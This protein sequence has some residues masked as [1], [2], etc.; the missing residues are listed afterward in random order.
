MKFNEDYI[1]QDIISKLTEAIKPA[2][3]IKKTQ[4]KWMLKRC[5]DV[6]KLAA[7]LEKDIQDMDSNGVAAGAGAIQSI[8]ED[9]LN[10]VT[11]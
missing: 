9:I 5:Q 11:K 6:K 7:D 8:A 1:M 3:P 2:R 4:Q 10:S